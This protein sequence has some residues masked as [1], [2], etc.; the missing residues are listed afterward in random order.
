LRVIDGEV[1]PISGA[2]MVERYRADPQP[3]TVLLSGIGHYPQIEAPCRCSSTTWRF[4]ISRCC[5]RSRW[6]VP[7]FR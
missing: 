4:A 7:E 3:D 5:R 2:H 6:R 1:D